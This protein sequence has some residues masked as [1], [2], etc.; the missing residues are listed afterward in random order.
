MEELGE[1][2][3]KADALHDL[4]L[5]AYERGDYAQAKERLD[6]ALDLIPENCSRD[7]SI[8]P[9]L[10]RSGVARAEGNL[11]QARW[12]LEEA[13]KHARHGRWEL[14]VLQRLGELSAQE[15]DSQSARQQ[16]RR[17]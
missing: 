2:F 4:A 7:R 3:L 8:R 5:T 13:L 9:L 12:L 16:S 10:I 6:Q 14:V 11:D 1:D 17:L 15:G